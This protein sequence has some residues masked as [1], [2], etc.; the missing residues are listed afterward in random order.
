MARAKMETPQ[1]K[2]LKT[3]TRS[4]EAPAR[5]TFLKHQKIIFNKGWS[6]ERFVQ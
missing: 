4:D 2:L 5:D 3:A 1:E 6:F